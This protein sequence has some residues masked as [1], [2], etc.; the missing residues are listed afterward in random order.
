V[1]VLA[2]LSYH[3]ASKYAQITSNIAQRYFIRDLFDAACKAEIQVFC[4]IIRRHRV[5]NPQHLNLQHR[6]HDTLKSR[7]WRN[8]LPDHSALRRG[9]DAEGNGTELNQ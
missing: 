1:L 3:D 6:R 7:V 4:S 2:Q 5:N 9:N 8:G